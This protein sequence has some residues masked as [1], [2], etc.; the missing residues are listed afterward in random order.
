MNPVPVMTD[1]VHLIPRQYEGLQGY[2][3]I[4]YPEMV[5]LICQLPY[6][7]L[8]IEVGAAS[9]VTT[10]LIRNARP[11]LLVHSIDIL[12][13]VR[14]GMPENCADRVED[15]DKH[16]IANNSNEDSLKPEFLPFRLQRYCEYLHFTSGINFVDLKSLSIFID[17]DHSYEGVRDDLRVMY[18]WLFSSV[19]FSRAGNPIDFNVFCHD[20]GC[21][22]WPGVQQAVDEFCVERGWEICNRVNSLITL[23]PKL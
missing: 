16:W 10:R 21:Q 12:S 23:R 22:D 1:N 3:W 8:F 6:E 11:D 20:Y 5:A 13:T 4:S 15:R 2:S 7:G 19:N 18:R 17:G 9:G 14:E